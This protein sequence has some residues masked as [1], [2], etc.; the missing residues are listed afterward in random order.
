MTSVIGRTVTEDLLARFR[1][2]AIPTAI[3]DRRLLITYVRAHD[4]DQIDPREFVL[5]PSRIWNLAET[6]TLGAGRAPAGV[7]VAVP[8]LEQDGLQNDA[9]PRLAVR[10]AFREGQWWVSNHASGSATIVLSAPGAQEELSR[11]SPAWPVRRRRCIVTVRS[12]GVRESVGLRVEHRITLFAPWIPDDLPQPGT[13]SSVTG[14]D[15]GT[16]ALVGAPDWSRAQQ[17]LLAAWAYPELIGLASSGQ[18][19]GRTARMLLRQALT[20]DDPNERTLSGMRRR[21]SRELGIQLSGEVHTPAFL[22]YVVTRR[23]HLGDALAELHA[24]YDVLAG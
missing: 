10:L 22:D 12:R 1:P 24:E 14:A 2:P 13:H 6:A 17:R 18:P 11:S 19:R 16:T 4:L 3:T 9:V 21:A 5:R 8:L 23:E 7:D 20:G 15:R